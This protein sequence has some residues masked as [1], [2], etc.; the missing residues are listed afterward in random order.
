MGLV[1]VAVAGRGTADVRRY[2]W[3]GDRSEN[4]RSS[5]GAAIELL[6]ARV[7]VGAPA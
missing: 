1:Y 3:P 7:E 4:K 2:L 6:L 5:A